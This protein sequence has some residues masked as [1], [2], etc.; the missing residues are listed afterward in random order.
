MTEMTRAN[1][2]AKL[3]LRLLAVFPFLAAGGVV[4]LWQATNG[5]RMPMR[6]EVE[7]VKLLGLLGCWSAAFAFDRGEYMRRAWLAEGACYFFLVVRDVT[8]GAW[9]P[10]APGPRLLGV[11][12]EVYE[13][14]LVLV[15]NINA[16]V[17]S[18][19]LARAW[20]VAGLGD[21]DD[22]GRRRMLTLVAAVIAIVVVGTNMLTDLRSLRGGN[23]EAGVMIASDVGDV[24]GMALI[25]PVL[26]TA[27]AMRGGLLVWPWALLTASMLGWL[28]YDATT[29]VGH[30]VRGGNSLRLTGEVFR[31]LACTFSFSAGLAQRISVAE[32]T[33]TRA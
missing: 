7:T 21:A 11:P 28:F 16:V 33:N 20:S 17:G 13:S 30:V 31:A 9:T 18:L 27:L 14:A 15:A 12:T 19:M 25:A 26:L 5:G 22:R 23:L 6:I 2:G 8:L 4:V 10:W 3:K 1:T 24:I 32:N 29:T